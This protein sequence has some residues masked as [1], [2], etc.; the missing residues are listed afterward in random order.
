M[1]RFSTL[2][3]A[4]L[5]AAMGLGLIG[6]ASLV[7]AEEWKFALEEIS[8]SVQDAYAQKFKQLVEQKSDGKISVTVYPYGALGESEDLTELVANGVLQFAH[9]STGILGSTAPSM[10]VFSVPYLLSQDNQVN[11]KVL[12]E[13]PTIYGPMADKLKTRNLRLLSMYPEGEMVWTTN[14][15]VRKPADFDNV[16]MRVMASPMLV[17]TY[18]SFGAVPTPLPYSEV[19]GALQLKMIDGQE[20]PIFA[21]EEMK[22]YEVTD[23]LTWSG[24]QQFT[25]AVLSSE[26]WYQ[27]LPAEQQK[28]IDETVTELGPYIFD[29]QAQYNKER[30]AK[31]QQLKPGIE[32]VR[33]NEEE[34]AAFRKASLPMRD[35]LVELAGPEAG[36]T[37]QALEKEIAALE[38]Q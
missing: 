24:H 5:V 38:Q 28:I 11:L 16:K 25:V 19:Y 17:E 18:K 29:T 33:L 6:Q 13:S 8:G 32:L 10:Q 9:G 35:K 37:L 22:F 1:S 30:L 2:K 26:S 36:A 23:V 31:I 27:G 3:K 15:V 14:K 7:A 4:A 20:N 21:I 12:T 34:Q